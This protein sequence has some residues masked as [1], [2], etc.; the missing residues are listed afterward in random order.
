LEAAVRIAFVAHPALPGGWYRGIGPMVALHKRYGYEIRQVW[1]PP[2]DVHPEVVPG[3]D[4]LH[5]HRRHD[6]DTLQMVRQAKQRGMA[7][8]Y[9]NDDDMTAVPKNNAAYRE[10]GGLAGERARAQISKLVRMA[11]L[12]TTPSELIAERFREYGAEHVQV[13]E[14]YV[15]DAVLD[16]RAP[17]NGGELTIGWIAGSEH[18][19]DVERVPIRDA[20][21]RLLDAHEHVRVKTIGVGLGLRHPRYEHVPHV[22]FFDL[23]PALATFDVGLAVLADIAFNQ[24]RSNIKVKEYAALGKPWLAS[25][26][27]PYAVLGEK[28]GGR[29]VPD[30]RWFEQLERLALAP[31]DLRKLAKRAAKWGSGQAISANAPLWEGALRAALARARG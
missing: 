28:Q 12:V 31:R 7:V 11:D 26:V 24:G 4:V 1:R 19:L 16:T 22:D 18:H 15:P 13:I 3:C 9:D 27:G 20:L 17:S 8:V 21:G 30:D 6:D 5:I 14:N 25:P 10:Y 23:P 29:L 2:E